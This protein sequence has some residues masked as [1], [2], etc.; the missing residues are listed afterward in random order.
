MLRVLGLALAIVTLITSTL[1][2]SAPNSQLLPAGITLIGK[3]V[4]SGSLLDTSGL[5]GNICQ[6]S[7]PANCVPLQSSTTGDCNRSG[8]Q[9]FFLSALGEHMCF[10]LVGACR[11]AVFRRR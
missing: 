4:I 9:I 8:L 2:F 1:C 10:N 7:A 5:T 6:A 3:G 11:D